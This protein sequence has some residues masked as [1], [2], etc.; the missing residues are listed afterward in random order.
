MRLAVKPFL[1][2]PPDRVAIERQDLGQHADRFLHRIDDQTGDAGVDDLGHRAATEGEHRRAASHGFDHRQPERFRPVDREQQRPGLAQELALGALVDLADE[3]HA[4]LVEQRFDLLAEIGFVDLVD[5]GGDLDG[6]SAC[7]RDADGAVGPLLGRDAAEECHIVAARM[8]VGLEQIGGYPVI[9]RGDEVRAG[10]RP[11]LRVGD[12]HQ[13]HVA[14]ADIERLEVGEVLPAVGRR[15]GPTSHVP[16]QR[17]V[18]LV[19]VEM[20]DVEILRIAAD[21]VEHEHVVGDRVVDI[22]VETQRHRRAA[23]Q[24]G[25][26]DRVPAG[27]QRHLVALPHQLIREVGYNSLGSAIKPRWHALDERTNLRNF[28]VSW[29]QQRPGTGRERGAARKVP[30]NRLTVTQA[31]PRGSSLRRRPR[32]TTGDLGTPRIRPGM[33]YGRVFPTAPCPAPPT[34]VR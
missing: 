13:G 30:S 2:T 25:G 32:L 22:G 5:L 14:K 4:R 8:V 19:D 7:A 12:R 27:K 34:W 3:F 9:H 10:D 16:K 6:D 31:V 29:L 33:L 11:S 21:P 17:K 20:Q 26:G 23:D 24:V 15:H 1:E 18:K 28:H